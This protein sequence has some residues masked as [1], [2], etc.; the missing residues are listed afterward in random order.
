MFMGKPLPAAAKAG[1]Y[2]VE[3]QQNIMF[4]GP[5]AQLLDVSLRQRQRTPTLH[6]F[7]KHGCDFIRC[8]A[9]TVQVVKAAQKGV[10]GRI[11]DPYVAQNSVAIL[12]NM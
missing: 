6:R 7:D 5:P 11:S 10:S 12:A 9:P 3:Y 2:L 1:L 4:V 8:D